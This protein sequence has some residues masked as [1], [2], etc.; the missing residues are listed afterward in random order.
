MEDKLDALVGY[1]GYL[2]G[3]IIDGNITPMTLEEWTFYNY[4]CTWDELGT[5]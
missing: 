2:R 5:R 3:C 4:A 1:V